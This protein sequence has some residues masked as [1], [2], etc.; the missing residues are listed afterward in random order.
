[1]IIK[2]KEI[3]LRFLQVQE[4]LEFIGLNTNFVNNSYRIIRFK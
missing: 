3:L 1:M 2:K 4:L